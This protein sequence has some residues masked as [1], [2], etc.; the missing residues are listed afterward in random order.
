MLIGLTAISPVVASAA[1][2]KQPLPN[3]IYI[4]V[5]DMGYGDLGCYGQP[6][7]E[8]PHIDRMAQ[9]GMRFTQ[10]YAGSP[11]SAPSRATFMTGQHT[12][13]TL[14]RGNKGYSRSSAPI[15][16]GENQDWSLV[17]QHPYDPKH[18]I[19]PEIMKDN[20]YRTG[21]FGKWAGGYEGSASTP[22]KR[23][24]DEFYGYICQTTAHLY[25]PNFLNEFSRERGD[26][27]T[28]RVI[29]Q[30]NIQHPMFG[31]GYRN[32]TQYS[33]DLI[34]RRAMEWINKQ[35]ANHPF[36]SILTYTIPHAELVQPEDSLLEHYKQKFYEDKTWGG[37]LKSRYNAT[38][39]THAQFAAM[40]SR[41]DIYVGEIIAKLKEKG[42]DENTAIFFT[43]DNGPHEE[44]GADPAFF[45]RDG[46]LR[47]L[48][49]QC[50]EGG[51]RVP[52][53]VRWPGRVKSGS[54]TEQPIAF[55]DVLP[56][57]C[58][59][60][61]VK[62]YVDRYTNRQLPGDGF[63]GI[64]FLPALLGQEQTE[65]HPYLYWE[66]S[67]TDQFGVRWNDWK[68]IVVKGKPR[69]YNLATDLHEDHD[70]A[71]A[72]PDI[73]EK[74]VGFILQEHRESTLFPVTMPQPLKTQSNKA[75]KAFYENLPTKII[76]VEPVCIPNV[77][78]RLTDYDC[79]G[80]GVTLCTET[81]SKAISDLSAKGGGRLIAPQGV[82]LTGPIELQDNV[83]L[84]LERNAVIYFSPDKELYIDGDNAKGRAKPCLNATNKRNIAITGLGVIDGNGQQWRYI[85]RNK[86]S[87]V[88]WKRYH[89]MGGVE[90][91]GGETWY[92]WQMKSGYADI[93]QN[94]KRQEHMRNDLLHLDQ[95]E[96]VLIKDVTL[97][98]PP[99]FHL[100]PCYCRNVTIDGVTVRAPWNVQNAD[101]IDLS[102]C[103]QAL[104]VNCTVDVGDDGI[105]LKSSKP[106]EG[107]LAGCQ[108]IV[109]E[110][111]KVYNAHGGFVLG[112]NTA[113]GMRD[114]VV[115]HNTYSGTNTGL[116]FKSA[117][118]RGGRTERIFI[119][120]IAMTDIR[121]EAIVFQCDYENR[122][123]NSLMKTLAPE[124]GKWMPAFQ[125]IH[126]DRI[127]CREAKTAIKAKGID[128]QQCI[129]DINISNST[130]VYTDKATAIDTT[131]A[132]LILTEVLLKENKK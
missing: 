121:E 2:N 127:T 117:P 90:L 33:A 34:H 17:G 32:R 100:H 44:G 23:G 112:S 36:I 102:D 21:M 98:N 1:E 22:D 30:E 92:P 42:L 97:Q 48:K 38:E 18:I 27:A 77:E 118:D 70:V 65:Q 49:R 87:D 62:D 5:D 40:I 74:M 31:P 51:I 96:N 80:D 54:V 116:R 72:H 45:G 16:Y 104:I 13:H 108:D 91:D 124:R 53:I 95:C 122:K 20:G 130:F 105:C 111:N 86:M 52:F 106:Q 12:G 110:N 11:V 68:L 64:S 56:T 126:I 46:K 25:Y 83:E 131:T 55:Y 85:K 119:S 35:D 78:M 115:R 101:G 76:P 66:F 19:L 113:G 37:N 123:G 67:E 129:H 128:G 109:V 43:S 24:I 15:M 79:K 61:G 82:W 7:I 93:A 50:Y 73:V 84:H 89:E 69:L 3:I 120:D 94:A 75:Y 71:T 4:M 9:E 10:A 28:N 59:M 26:T 41:L 39:H 107:K 47:G 125:D 57:F 8:T 81:F 63:D 58:D 29:L 103:H 132:K 88:E 99:R 14:I 6:Y 60:I 114:I